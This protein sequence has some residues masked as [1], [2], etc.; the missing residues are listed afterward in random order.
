MKYT[1]TRNSKV[2]ISASQAIVK[3]ISDDGGLF[4]PSSFPI[5]SEKRLRRPYR[6]RLSRSRRKNL[7]LIY[8]RVF[9]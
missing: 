1:S 3:G 2:E 6:A 5:L 9:F 4:V 7:V 8:G